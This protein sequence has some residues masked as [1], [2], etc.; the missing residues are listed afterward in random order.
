MLNCLAAAGSVVGYSRRSRRGRRTSSSRD[1]ALTGS[2]TCNVQGKP[3]SSDNPRNSFY[4]SPATT[5]MPTITETDNRAR[6]FT[7]LLQFYVYVLID[8]RYGS[9]FYVGEGQRERA[10]NHVGE[11]R[12]LIAKGAALES[13]KHQ[14]IKA[15]LDSNLEPQTRVIARFDDKEK[16]HAVESVM[17]N[18]VYDYDNVLT[19]AVRGHG[20]EFVRRFGDMRVLSG[21][22][23]PERARSQDGTFKNKNVDGLR[24]A[25]AYDLLQRI[26]QHLS[27]HG[28]ALR[29]F[30]PGTPDSPFDP[31]QS[32][33]WLGLIVSVHGIDFMVSFS[34]T[35]RPAVSIA[36][37]PGTR[38]VVAYACLA[39]IE[40]EMGP[41]FHAGPPKNI[42]VKGEGRYRDFGRQNSNGEFEAKKPDFDADNLEPLYEL[43][44][45]FARIL[46]CRLA[47]P[48]R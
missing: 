16:A 38:N 46:D 43:M 23:I 2:T 13:A 39:Q 28:F 33:G 12:Q 44:H 36:N 26:R 25:G 9:V 29:D 18:F 30:L 32:N 14:T 24:A 22:D 42:R 37:T 5:L 7:E 41:E 40:A 8:P 19:N 21:I 15:I 47:T 6:E 35:C 4:T 3:L 31:G 45:D 34:K 11:V 10:L 20:A 48:L 1:L 27:E 17:I